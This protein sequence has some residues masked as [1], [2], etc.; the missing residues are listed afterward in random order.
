MLQ[1]HLP[2]LVIPISSDSL[3]HRE[4]PST[5]HWNR[6][7]GHVTT[8]TKALKSL[9]G[10]VIISCLSAS[11]PNTQPSRHGTCCKDCKPA[12]QTGIQHV[13]STHSS[14]T[15][16]NGNR[17]KQDNTY[18]ESLAFTLLTSRAIIRLDKPPVC[19]CEGAVPRLPTGS[20]CCN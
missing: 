9:R 13:C 15:G 6:E 14:N 11:S 8:P 3:T 16:E 19:N 17:I 1:Y 12:E 7:P 10:D 18:L 20:S 4:N 2:G 5:S